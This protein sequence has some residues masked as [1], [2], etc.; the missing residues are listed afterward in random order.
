M[1]ANQHAHL[2][3]LSFDRSACVDHRQPKL[4]HHAIVLFEYPALKDLEALFRIVGPAEV[5]ARLVIF[6]IGPGGYD[7]IDCDVEWRA[8]EESDGWFHCERIDVA[9]PVAIATASDVAC[10]GRVDVTIRE[11]DRAGFQGRNDVALG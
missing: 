4:R 5:H 8:E 11:H 2:A 3:L 9:H 10:E 7:A 6:Q 1:L